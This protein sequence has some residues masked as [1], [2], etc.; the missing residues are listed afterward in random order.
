MLSRCFVLLDAQLEQPVWWRWVLNKTLWK[1]FV[2]NEYFNDADIVVLAVGSMDA[3]RCVAAQ[4]AVCRNPL[5]SLCTP[6]KN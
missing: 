3:A 6:M 1:D 5:L 2:R 4:M